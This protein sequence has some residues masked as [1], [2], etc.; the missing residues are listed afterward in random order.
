MKKSN[1]K[2]GLG[3]EDLKLQ[4]FEKICREATEGAEKEMKSVLP[5]KETD[6]ERIKD[7]FQLISRLLDKISPVTCD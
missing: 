2:D 3:S 1:K 4:K 6:E 5:S 7:I